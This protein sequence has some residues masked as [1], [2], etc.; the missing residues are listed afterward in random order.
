[1]LAATERA[2]TNKD[3][4]EANATT[5]GWQGKMA[6]I[7]TEKIR[8]WLRGGRAEAGGGREGGKSRNTRFFRQPGVEPTLDREISL[9][10]TGHRK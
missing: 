4:T 5:S 1:M 9:S 7:E 6:A 3:G 10:M 8:G 2:R